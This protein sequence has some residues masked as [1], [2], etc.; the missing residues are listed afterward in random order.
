MLNWLHQLFDYPG[1]PLPPPKK[2][3]RG[4]AEWPHRPCKNC[5]AIKRVITSNEDRG[6]WDRR[7]AYCG[8]DNCWIPE[9]VEWIYC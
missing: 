7:C 8:G 3:Y 9:P 1:P 4:E 5:G 2:P 6:G